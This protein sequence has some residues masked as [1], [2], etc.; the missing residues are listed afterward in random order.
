MIILPALTQTPIANR[1]TA[2][3]PSILPKNTGQRVSRTKIQAETIQLKAIAHFVNASELT[4]EMFL[5]RAEPR[6]SIR[7]CHRASGSNRNQRAMATVKEMA[8]KVR[9]CGILPELSAA[10]KNP[11]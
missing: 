9:H 8:A 7:P 11:S 4:W 10:N 6:T 3:D 5:K 1:M 2:G